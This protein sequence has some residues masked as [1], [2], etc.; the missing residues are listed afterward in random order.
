MNASRANIPSYA[1]LLERTDAPPGSSWGLFGADDE[2][3]TLNFLTPERILDAKQCIRRG[4]YFNFDCP[5]DAFD[6]PILAHRKPLKHTIIGSSRH[7]RDDFIDSFY[8]QSGSQIDGLRHFRHPVHGFYNRAPDDSI[9]EGTPRLGINRVVEHGVVGRGVLIDVERY[10]ARRGERLDYDS[11]APISVALVDEIAAE[12]GVEFRSG[13][14]LL[15]RTGWMNHYFTSMTDE[16]RQSFPQRMCS[17][18]LKQGHDTLAWLWDHQ[19]SVGASDN[20]GLECFPPIED[21]PF[22]AE[23]KS[24]A[25][26]HPR[27]TH[28]MHA[29][30]IALL[31]LTIGEQ[32]DL[33]TLA[34]DCASDGVWECFVS[35]KPIN[36]VGAVGSPA[37]AFALK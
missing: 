7:H 19:F 34:D 33:E 37:N 22:A 28:M 24:V 30:M 27:H 16:Q 36:L 3:G 32:W 20:F 21:S 17:P 1:E 2:L 23:S 6:P 10:L 12:Q 29:H 31:G 11:G 26:I 15:L 14:I 35:V 25:D 4:T 8:M 5:I 13:D 18:G 9:V